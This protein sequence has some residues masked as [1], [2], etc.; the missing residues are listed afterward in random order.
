MIKSLNSFE[1]EKYPSIEQFRNVI[2]KVKERH[3]YQG[4]DEN[5]D[6]IYAHTSNYP[7]LKFKGTVKLHGTNAG[8]VSYK[9]G[10]LEFQSRE[11]V[12]SE[13]KDN[14]D[15]MKS[16]SSLDLDS[17]FSGIDFNDYIAIY[18]EWCG[19]NIQKGVALN[20]LPKM[21]VIFGC[22]VDD[23][24]V[25]YDR[26]ENLKNIYN[27]NQFPTYEVDIDFNNPELVQNALIDMT[28]A[29]EDCCPV[30]KYFGVEGVGEGIVFTCID[31]PDLKFKSK[32]EKHSVSKVKKLNPVD[33][34]V[35][36]GI[37]EFVE[38]VVTENRLEQGV[39][40]M[41][42]NGIY[43]DSKN[44][45]EF[46]RWVVNDVLK[47]ETDTILESNLDDKKLKSAITTKAR[48]WYLNRL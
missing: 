43:P 33:T 42:E 18:G 34:E 20:G 2:R 48:V 1:D 32:G 26:H 16:M 44:T 14:A 25:D 35:V 11:R 7:T 39:Q 3:D 23:V 46:L 9:D 38:K 36:K 15:F 40:V 30:G 27:I 12:L 31:Q 37:N 22:M 17:L 29:V 41:K 13:D 21:F 45:G 19:G 5:N 6:P 10:R 24:W 47:E 8:I 4:R 28:I